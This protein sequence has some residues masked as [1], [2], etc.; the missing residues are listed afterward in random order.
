MITRSVPEFCISFTVLFKIRNFLAAQSISPGA[1]FIGGAVD[2]SSARPAGAYLGAMPIV[3]WCSAV[4]CSMPSKYAVGRVV[5]VLCWSQSRHHQ[6][7]VSTDAIAS[8]LITSVAA[9]QIVTVMVPG[10][11]PER[12]V[13]SMHRAALRSCGMGSKPRWTGG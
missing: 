1:K 10:P 13:T 12:R 6:T 3:A 2:F 11:F 8:M 5:A 4:R 9:R 7:T